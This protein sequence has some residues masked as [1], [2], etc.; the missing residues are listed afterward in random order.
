MSISARVIQSTSEGLIGSPEPIL[1]GLVIPL[2]NDDPIQLVGEY[3]N[4]MGRAFNYS[5]KNFT[6]AIQ[7]GTTI[8]LYDREVMKLTL[9]FE[10]AT[11]TVNRFIS[12][13][14]NHIPFVTSLHSAKPQVNEKKNHTQIE[15][16]IQ[17]ILTDPTFPDFVD[18]VERI[19]CRLVL[20][21]E[22]P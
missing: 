11:V 1:I 5:L 14:R 19:I 4:Q 10:N 8:Q 13:L 12:D 17:A 20:S 7:V 21:K 6:H 15:E 2:T 22:S 16:N 9:I 18:N 3:P